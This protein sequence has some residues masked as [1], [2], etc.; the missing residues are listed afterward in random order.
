MDENELFYKKSIWIQKTTFN[1]P[2]DHH[3]SKKVSKASDKGNIVVGVFL[4]LK[5]AFDAVNHTIY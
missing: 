4:D 3:I 5:K 2:R 1:Q